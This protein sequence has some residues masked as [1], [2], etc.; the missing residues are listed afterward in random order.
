MDL[1]VMNSKHHLMGMGGSSSSSTKT[2]RKIIEKNRRNQMKTLYAQLNSLIP[3][4]QEAQALP[5]QIDEAIGYIKSLEE[6]LKKSKE[7]KESLMRLCRKR[8]HGCTSEPAPS[9]SS[10]TLCKPPQVQIREMG[11]TLEIVL[12]TGLENQ[13]LFC[14]L[15][16]ILHEEGAEVVSANSRVTGDSAFHVVHAQMT[17]EAVLGFGSAKVTERLNRFI[18]GSTSEIDDLDTEL[19]DFDLQPD[20]TWA[21]L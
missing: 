15:L 13:F 3:H 21:F 20:E 14:D 5:D 12:V 4:H 6:K 7:K 1:M 11:T 2:E 16:R 10:S 17:N 9:S 8:S 18:N 19:W